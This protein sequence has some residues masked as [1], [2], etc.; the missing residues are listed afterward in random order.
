M[1]QEVGTIL[2]ADPALHSSVLGVKARSRDLLD[3]IASMAL[4]TW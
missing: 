1:E 4:L 2:S 3:R